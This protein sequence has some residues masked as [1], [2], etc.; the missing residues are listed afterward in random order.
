MSASIKYIVDSIKS[1]LL[2]IFALPIIINSGFNFF[3][4]FNLFFL[5]N[6]NFPKIISFILGT[7]FFVYLSN[8]LNKKFLL[9]S[10][11][12]GLVFYLTS[13]FIFDSVLLFIGKKLSFQS[14]FLLIS[15]FWC[16]LILYKTK[17]FVE[18]FKISILLFVYKAFNNFF[19]T[20]LVDNSKYKELNTDVPAQWFD[21]A[22]MIYQNNYFFALENNLIEGQGLLPSYIQALLFEIGF[23][24]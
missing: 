12:I 2:L 14:T 15:F 17:S 3:K 7:L 6:I 4:K 21:L 18:I 19:F 9:G 5:N 11:S 23:N 16:I 1:N 8:L 10:R 20:D 22:G 13:Y 24:Y